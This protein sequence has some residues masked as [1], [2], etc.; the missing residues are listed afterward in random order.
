M[1]IA[2]TK[3]IAFTIDS[4]K[5]YRTS[6]SQMFHVM[7]VSEM[8]YVKELICLNTVGLLHET[9]LIHEFKN[10]A[11][12]CYNC[13]LLFLKTFSTSSHK[14][15]SVKKVFLEISQNSQENTC[16]R[17]SFLIKLQACSFIKKE[18]LAQAFLCEFC[19]ISKNIFFTE[20]LWTTA[21][22]QR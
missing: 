14:G 11:K 15:C 4:L 1:L 2:F 17:A 10:F 8:S 19:E 7:V 3:A 9:L 21:S 6:C 22:A 20:H 18:T 13:Q 12:L 16:A 5:K